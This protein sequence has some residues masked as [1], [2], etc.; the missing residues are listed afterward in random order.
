MK[1]AIAMIALAFAATGAAA[2]GDEHSAGHTLL[3]ADEITW[4]AGPPSLPRG[5]QMAVLYGDPGAEGLFALRLR[6][7][8]GYQIPL[9]WHPQTE[10]VTVISGVFHIGMG[11]AV[12]PDT[13]RALEA[14]GFFAFPSGMTHF[15]F[16]EVETVVQ[17]NSIGPW[18]INYVNPE[19]DPRTAQ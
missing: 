13:A 16:T 3:D 18:A 19:D 7:P 1:T 5:A 2:A 17:L 15:A 10:V 12:D 4:A 9:H 8:A 6:L 11:D 14:G